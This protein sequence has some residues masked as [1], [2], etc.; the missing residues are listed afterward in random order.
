MLSWSCR[1][2][3]LAALQPVLVHAAG[4]AAPAGPGLADF[5]QTLLALLLV[6]GLIVCAALF[7]RRFSLL[8]NAVG[9]RLRVISGVLVG[10]KE[11]VVIVEV[12]D[13]WLVLGVTSQSVNL[14]HTLPRPAD[15]PP[16]PV[17][18][19]PAFAEKLAQILKQR[20]ERPGA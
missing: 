4:S 20:R 14:L 19:V 10:G 12:E 13:S 3:A 18:A 15:A 11:R 17:P 7:L 9:G 6:L 5:G 16:P 8:P 2:V 1:L